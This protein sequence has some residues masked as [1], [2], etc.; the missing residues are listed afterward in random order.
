MN[1]FFR[2]R[3]HAMD[4]INRHARDAVSHLHGAHIE[5]ACHQCAANHIGMIPHLARGL[6]GRAPL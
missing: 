4:E 2:T 3:V 5:K 1:L 6:L